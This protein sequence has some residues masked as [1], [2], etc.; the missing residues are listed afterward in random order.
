MTITNIHKPIS[1]SALKANLK[2]IRNVKVVIND[3]M[4]KLDRLALKITDKVGSVGFFTIIF[5]WTFLWLLW[6][7]LAPERLKFDP[8]PAFVFWLFLSNMIQIFLMPL[9]LIGQNLQSKQNDLRAEND[10]DINIK[11]EKE[12]QLVLEH[13]EYQNE[14]ILKILEK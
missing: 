5:C 4:S 1:H 3:Q 12:I 9:L 14:L 13:L 7:T 10:F 6:N 11:A 8:F 2:P